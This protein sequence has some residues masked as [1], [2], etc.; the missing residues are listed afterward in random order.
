MP[1][2]YT[3]GQSVGFYFILGALGTSNLVI[4]TLSVLTSFIASAFTFLRSPYYAIA[5]SVND[6]VLITMWVLATLER[7][8]YVPMIFCFVMF[9]ANDI[10]GFIN[11]KRLGKEQKS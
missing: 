1:K 3:Y 2:I 9:L 6:L 8:E 10:Y 11:W 4:S 5:Y 7:P